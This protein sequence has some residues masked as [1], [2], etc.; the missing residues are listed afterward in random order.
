MPKQKIGIVA[1]DDVSNDKNKYLLAFKSYYS[2]SEYEFSVAWSSVEE[3]ISYIENQGIA[4]INELNRILIFDNA[5]PDQSDVTDIV[6]TFVSLEEVMENR[7]A[8]TPLLSFATVNQEV[9][10]MFKKDASPEGHD[11]FVYPKTRIHRVKANVNGSVNLGSI[12]SILAGYEDQNAL[13]IRNDYEGRETLARQQVKQFKKDKLNGKA[14]KIDELVDKLNNQDKTQEKEKHDVDYTKN[15]IDKLKEKAN[16]QLNNDNDTTK[17]ENQPSKE[18]LAKEEAKLNAHRNVENAKKSNDEKNNSSIEAIDSAMNILREK[19]LNLN[20]RS[21]IYNDK[22]IIIV[23]GLPG[24]GVS[25]VVANLA[26]LY[27]MADK[28]VLIANYSNNDHITRYFKNFKSMYEELGRKQVLQ[29]KFARKLKELS[30]PTFKGI[31]VISD[32]GI[33]QK[34]Y[35]SKER[36]SNYDKVIRASSQYDVVII[37]AGDNLEDVLLSTSNEYINDVLV[38]STQNDLDELSNDL[39]QNTKRFNIKIRHLKNDVGLILNKMQYYESNK[40]IDKDIMNLSQPFDKMRLIGTI[41]YDNEWFTQTKSGYPIISRSSLVQR[42]FE[43][44]AK[45]II[46]K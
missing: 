39:I 17:E 41:S 28:S 30:V 1:Y 38:V 13:A 34:S 8:I 43:E 9:Y 19:S 10:D 5:F 31:N 21:K 24:S 4:T 12:N 33:T 6:N 23:G 11:L 40:E 22:G 16:N 20:Y 3:L 18:S 2:Q 26:L 32:Y 36:L 37:L 25:S 27:A 14:A 44:I 35:N 45:N 42:E 46:M 7:R 15:M 29:T